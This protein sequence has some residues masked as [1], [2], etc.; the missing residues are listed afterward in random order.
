MSVTTHVVKSLAFLTVI[1]FILFG[2]DS[3][4]D[5]K[6]PRDP[7][8]FRSVLD[9]QARMVT[10]ALHEN[11]YVAYDA[12]ACQLYKAWKG[13]VIFDG[14]VYTTNHGPQPTSKGYAYYERPETKLFWY[15]VKDGQ[16]IGLTPQFKGYSTKDNQVTFRY[17]LK[18]TEVLNISIE[19][20]P[21][22]ES[23]GNKT[24]LKRT[25][26]TSNLPSGVEIKIKTVL[27]NQTES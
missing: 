26:R 4:N 19:E 17:E 10:A 2:C 23:K 7:F 14:A 3:R 27:T 21:E 24:G 1:S 11:L 9:K 22:Y 12:Q 20:T 15:A 8:V 25:F 13:G 6:R 18:G 5:I 16:E